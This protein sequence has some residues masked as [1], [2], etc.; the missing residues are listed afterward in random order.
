MRFYTAA[1]SARLCI[2]RKQYAFLGCKY[3]RWLMLSNQIRVSC[4][5]RCRNHCCAGRCWRQHHPPQGPPPHSQAQCWRQHCAAERAR[6][7]PAQFY[8]SRSSCP[9][10][11][12][13]E[14]DRMHTVDACC[15]C[16]QISSKTGA[17][18]SLPFWSQRLADAWQ[19]EK[20]FMQAQTQ[21]GFLCRPML[22]HQISCLPLLRAD[23][24]SRCPLLT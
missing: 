19:S 20:P 17:S 12:P 22:A 11:P 10:Y 24:L 2:S 16:P 14:G 18:L 7:R 4:K 15:D 8:R 23:L 6:R 5:L 21:K 3:T 1:G 13:G 9:A